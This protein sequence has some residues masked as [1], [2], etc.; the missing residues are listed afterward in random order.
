MDDLTPEHRR[1]A[2]GSG[3]R[4]TLFGGVSAWRGTAELHLGGLKP[5]SVLAFL[6]LAAPGHVDL[7]RLVDNV[8]GNEP[9][10]DPIRDLRTY[11]SRLRSALGFTAIVTERRGGYRL[12][13]PRS[14]HDAGRLEAALA[15]ARTI[16]PAL[17]DERIAGLIASLQ[18][19]VADTD[20][21]PLSGLG[22]T[23]AIIG[24]GRALEELRLSAEDRLVELLRAAG[25]R[26]DA[27]RLLEHLVSR[28]PLQEERWLAL[29]TILAEL[30][31]RGEALRCY[32][33]ARRELIKVGVAPGTR[34]QAIE[35]EVLA[36]D[37]RRPPSVSADDSPRHNLAPGRSALPPTRFV[38]VGGASVAYQIWGDGPIDVV[39]APNL[40]SH[41][42]AMADLP[43]YRE[44]IERLAAFSRLVVFDKRGNGMSDRLS[45]PLALD[46]RIRDIGAVMDAAGLQRAALI[47]VSEGAAMSLLFAARNPQRVACVVAAG[48]TA[49]GRLAA[50]VVT[51]E[52]HAEMIRRLRES[53]G[54]NRDWWI[55]EL[56]APSLGDAPPSVKQLYERFSRMSSTPTS[57]ALLWDLYGRMDIRDALPA[58]QCPVLVHYR[59]EESTRWAESMFMNGLRH[60]SLSLA[61]GCDHA[62]W[63]GDIAAYVDPIEKFLVQHA[64]TEVPK[65]RGRL[66]SAL[67]ARSSHDGLRLD[68]VIRSRTAAATERDGYVLAA[69]DLP[70]DAADCAAALLHRDPTVTVVIHTGE[71]RETDGRVGGPAIDLALQT[72][73][74]VQ[75]KVLICEMTIQLGIGSEHRVGPRTLVDATKLRARSL[76]PAASTG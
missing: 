72:C 17:D 56:A 21:T 35:A 26:E 15:E 9:P 25:R 69:F 23:P 8:W 59:D 68:Q 2:D 31:R 5:R 45:G 51:E 55:Y 54:T 58:V 37:Q 60:A 22:A 1:L 75:S 38:E 74:A 53:W 13:L 34:L 42:E 67:A 48:G 12:A 63:V 3:L 76:Q 71:I 29:V 39:L 61:P 11:V 41:L 36:A 43:G 32:Q 20:G 24:L 65:P 28:T 49:A 30:G 66:A 52:Q 10:V 27:T 50:G 40:V 18:A 16:D 47:G 6:A 73:R 44:W 7:A 64:D 33:R 70:A 62:Q 46:E 14:V 57:A 4:I 19:V